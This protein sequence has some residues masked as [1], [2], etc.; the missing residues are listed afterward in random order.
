MSFIKKILNIQSPIMSYG[1][2]RNPDVVRAARE[3]NETLDRIA[4]AEIK[5]KDRVDISKDEYERLIAQNSR[6]NS[7]N[8]RLRGLL[9][10]FEIPFDKPII[11]DSIKTCYT[12]DPIEFQT[13]YQVVFAVSDLEVK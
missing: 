1:N 2:V 9:A 12:I 5:S 6:L 4:K 3:F 8:A 7:E 11:E 10:K 13:I